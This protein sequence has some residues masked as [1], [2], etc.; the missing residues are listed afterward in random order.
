M[1]LS[2]NPQPNQNLDLGANYTSPDPQTQSV[3]GYNP[4]NPNQ[5]NYNWGSSNIN[6]YLGQDFTDPSGQDPLS[7][8]ESRGI[9]IKGLD[10]S[11]LAF[12]PDTKKLQTAFN[13]MN[14]QVG[15]A[16]TGLGF[17]MGA[18]Q[19]AGT[20][21]LL[22]MTGGMGIASGGGG[23]GAQNRNMFSNIGNMQ[24]QYQTGLNQSVAG[25]Q[26][27]ILGMQYDFQD[28]QSNYQDALTSALG[29]IMASGEDDFTVSL[30]STPN[31]VDNNP[32]GDGGL[33][34]DES[35]WFQS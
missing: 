25:F 4:T 20:Q 27:D 1:S 32:Y 3:S 30:A 15:M 23:F 5:Y 17:D 11:S 21:N 10:Q 22:G 14:T 26:S 12:L 28:A 2:F 29:N 8:L 35:R 7:F 34:Y 6:N 24:N 31:Q 13:R 18:Q 9:N 19:L 33:E 16:R